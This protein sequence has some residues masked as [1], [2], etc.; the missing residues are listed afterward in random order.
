MKKH[1]SIACAAAALTCFMVFPSFAAETRAEYKEEAAP[2]RS[3]LK[4]VN[5]EIAPLRAENRSVAAKY[6]SIRLEKK[7]TGTLSVSKE[8]W[9]KAKE[10]H[11]KIKEVHKDGSAETAKSLKAKAKADVKAKN[12]DSALDSMN[13]LL[14]LKKSRLET[15][16]ETNEIWKQIDELL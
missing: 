3:E 7:N 4:A 10:L 15:L 5:D 8:N 14:E 6:K 12:F 16:K 9:K 11:A 2:V 1:L 13:Q